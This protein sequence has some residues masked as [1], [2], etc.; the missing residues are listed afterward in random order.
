MKPKVMYVYSLLRMIVMVFAMVCLLCLAAIPFSSSAHAAAN[1]RGA[2]VVSPATTNIHQVAVLTDEDPLHGCAAG[3]ACVYPQDA[4]LNNDHPSQTFYYFGVYQLSNQYGNH[5]VLND[6]VGGA[7]FWLCTDWNG[8]DCPLY[9]PNGVGV[10]VDLTPINSVKL[11]STPDPM[12][13]S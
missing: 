12:W 10:E 3:Y 9:I 13:Y 2:S 11:S 7:S 1:T 6:Q 8:N 5:Y 4:G